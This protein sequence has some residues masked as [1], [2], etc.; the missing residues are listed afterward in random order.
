MNEIL[1]IAE[2][3]KEDKLIQ[4]ISTEPFL[5]KYKLHLSIATAILVVGVTA[6]SHYK[7][8]RL[9]GELITSMGD[10]QKSL[11]L[12][13]GEMKYRAIECSGIISTECNIEDIS[14]SM[15][16]EEQ[17]FIKSLHLGYVEDLGELREYGEGKSVDAS[18]DIEL[19]GVTLPPP[20]IAQ[21][22][23]QNV[24][25]TFQKSTLEKLRTL[26]LALEGEIEGS[27]AFIKHLEIDR[28][29]IDNTIMPIEFSMEARE[30][31]SAKP[32]SMILEH[33]ALNAENK[34]ISD[35]TYESVKSFLDTLHPSEQGAFLK[36]FSL[37]P[38]DM[39]DKKKAS[40]AINNAI[41]KRFESDLKLTQ[42]SIEKELIRAMMK[43]LQG[44]ASEVTLAGENQN[45]L[46]IAQ[47]QNALVQSSAMNEENAQKFMGDKFKLE[48][49]TN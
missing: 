46:T 13:G 48:V 12:I 49:E 40:R 25:N 21:I 10:Y 2:T 23:A 33:F 34:A 7:N 30:I 18:I 5:K 14:L 42:G 1:P 3:Q 44:T 27:S 43:I 16:G 39:K 26:D 28:F 4:N 35:V 9:K 47:V 24:G 37:I 31:S 15:L 32:D 29:R 17:F 11:M 22:V 41:A 6:F 45:D 19:S 36:E 20:L 38:T 8:D